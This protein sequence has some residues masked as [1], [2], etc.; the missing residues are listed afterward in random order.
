MADDDEYSSTSVDG[1]HLTTAMRV[2]SAMTISSCMVVVLVYLGDEKIRKKNINKI[3]FY[4]SISQIGSSVG[5]MLGQPYNGT[6]ECY[7]QALF[8]NIFPYVY[9]FW[10][11]IAAYMLYRV[12]HNLNPIDIDS[13]FIQCACWGIPVI[14]S[15]L[16]LTTDT[17]GNEDTDWG[18][19]YIKSSSRSPEWTVSFWVSVNYFIHT[20]C[21]VLSILFIAM[22]VYK[23]VRLSNSVTDQDTLK[24]LSK[25][26]VR[27]MWYPI[28]SFICWLPEGIYDLNDSLDKGQNQALK[29]DHAF[30]YFAFLLTISE[31]MWVAIAFFCTN[32]DALK[33]LKSNLLCYLPP[34]T[35]QS[36]DTPPNFRISSDP[37]YYEERDTMDLQA[38]LSSSNSSNRQ[39]NI[40]LEGVQLNPV[41]SSHS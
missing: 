5:T 15:L 26:I 36:T 2:T 7:T 16:P 22:S 31:G 1:G 38:A 29:N 18:W 8:T 14:L 34:E 25:N 3:V 13:T 11:T 19:C 27:F 23:V 12:V 9:T 28:I 17:F 10:T 40:H 4:I 21:V 20:V 41:I 6:P 39:R 35:N 32:D 33:V 24:K 37:E 30:T